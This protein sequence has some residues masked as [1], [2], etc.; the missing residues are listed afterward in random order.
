MLARVGLPVLAAV[1]LGLPATASAGLVTG[2]NAGPY[3][4]EP[5]AK[6]IKAAGIERVRVPVF[7]RDVQPIGP[8][9]WDWASTDEQV[10]LAAENSLT[11][12]VVLCGSPQW[13]IS[14]IPTKDRG[15]GD[16]IPSRP[17]DFA[18]F[19]RAI[20]SRYGT[21][22]S[23]WTANPTVP[24][25]PVIRWQ[26]WN[27]PNL[28]Y[29]AGAAATSPA[30]Y[31]K[32]FTAAATA[33]KAADSRS[34]IWVGGVGQGG[35]K[36]NYDPTDF[37][38]ALWLK[39]GNARAREYIW[40]V[41]VYSRTAKDVSDVITGLARVMSLSGCRGCRLVLGEYGWSSLKRSSSCFRCVGD[42]KAQARIGSDLLTLT[43][44]SAASNLLDATFW[45]RWEDNLD[46]AHLQ[47]LG[48]VRADG[49]AK[50][51][52]SVLTK[53]AKLP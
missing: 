6:A 24:K 49:T 22:G 10:R 2:I 47:G 53:F 21:K 40:D 33:I 36:T 13:A 15:S 23:F 14:A 30:K 8:G 38:Q 29:F 44:R 41:H 52:L 39:W 26:V 11:F 46:A 27:E 45:Y 35:R 19:A 51:L 18:S 42:E 16:T 37:L 7:W 12:D 50:P 4:G 3:L 5:A 48:A 34:R 20:V 9:S 17:A 43:R 31:E 28:V 32:L 1:A 25:R